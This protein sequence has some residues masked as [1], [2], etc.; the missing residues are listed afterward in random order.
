[1]EVK[2][3]ATFYLISKGVYGYQLLHTILNLLIF[4]FRSLFFLG[5][6]ICYNLKDATIIHTSEILLGDLPVLGPDHHIGS[7]P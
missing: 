3:K 4:L 1:M 2:S 7:E 5:P 6:S